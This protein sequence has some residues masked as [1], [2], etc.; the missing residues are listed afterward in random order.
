MLGRYGR[1][2]RGVETMLTIVNALCQL[3]ILHNKGVKQR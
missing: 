2:E 1:R 3:S